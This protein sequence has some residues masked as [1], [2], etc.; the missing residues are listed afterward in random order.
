MAGW[1]RQ[2]HRGFPVAR[3]AEPDMI[4]GHGV[5]TGKVMLVAQTFENPL[6]REDS[7]LSIDL[8]G[9]LAGILHVAMTGL[10]PGGASEPR[11]PSRPI[12]L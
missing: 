10:V 4:L 3:Q 11:K 6:G 2:R 1:M 5:A 7:G 8:R 12:R 9:D